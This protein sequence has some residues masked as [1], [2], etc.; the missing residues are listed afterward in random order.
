VLKAPDAMEGAV[1]PSLFVKPGDETAELEPV[2]HSP[3]I[4][5]GHAMTTRS[6]LVA[7]QGRHDGPMCPHCRRVNP[8]GTERWCAFCAGDM[9]PPP[10][11]P[12]RPPTSVTPPIRPSRRGRWLVVL[13][14]VVLV[15]GIGLG[16]AL[17]DGSDTRQSQPSTTPSVVPSRLNPSTIT[18]RASNT[19]VS[20]RASYAIANTLDGR[21]DTAWN[22]N[23]RQVG[24]G[25]GVTL[26]YD[27]GRPVDL[28]AIVVRN[29]YVRSPRSA[30]VYRDNGRLRVVNVRTASGTFTW[31]LR[32]SPDPQQIQRPFGTT[33]SVTITVRSVYPGAKYD[34]LAVTD[35]AFVATG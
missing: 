18:A 35:V 4:D 10:P 5:A 21:D 25:K 8:A 2:S 31:E 15:V 11:A 19:L 3:Q 28:R 16:W 29:G 30:T 13:L 12:V 27:F 26:M 6:G 17:L 34:D 7:D 23:G 32:D 24:S 9:M 1:D 22:S 33:D 14:V 20:K